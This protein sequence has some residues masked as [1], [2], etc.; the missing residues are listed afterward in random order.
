MEALLNSQIGYSRF[1]SNLPSITT[2][3]RII[4]KSRPDASVGYKLSTLFLCEHDSRWYAWDGNAH[5]F[6]GRYQ[7]NL[8]IR[9]CLCRIN[10]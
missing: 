6:F 9:R 4:R 2:S 10:L 5:L 3:P 8:A 1:K 7:A